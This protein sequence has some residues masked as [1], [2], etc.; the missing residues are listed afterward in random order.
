MAHKLDL[1]TPSLLLDLEV[2]ERNIRDYADVARRHNVKLRPHAK[3]PKVPAICHRQLAAGAVGVCV[4][5]VEEAWTMVGTGITD[6][7][8]PYP[9][10]G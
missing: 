7:L 2:M 9:I 3:T 4:A 5:T 1:K 10:T 6:L 8:I